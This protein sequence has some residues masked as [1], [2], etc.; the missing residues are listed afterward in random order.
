MGIYNGDGWSEETGVSDMT[1]R[2]LLPSALYRSVTFLT[3]CCKADRG[4]RQELGNLAVS[5]RA[6]TLPIV[7][8]V[9]LPTIPQTRLPQPINDSRPALLIVVMLW[10]VV[11]LAL[12][13]LAGGVLA[14]ALDDA[15]GRRRLDG[16]AEHVPGQADLGV[17]WQVL[18]DGGQGRRRQA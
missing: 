18:H 13:G 5:G 11:V 15:D 3:L 14:L 7:L 2:L 1:R 17:P 10:H 4:D 12:Q 16:L 9:L 6:R 8:L